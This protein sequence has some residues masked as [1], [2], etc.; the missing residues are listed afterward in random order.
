[1]GCQEAPFQRAIR[2]AVWFPARVNFP[3]ITRSPW[4]SMASSTS[5]LVPVPSPRALQSW[6]IEAHEKSISANSTIVLF[7]LIPCNDYLFRLIPDKNRKKR[8]AVNISPKA[9]SVALYPGALS[10]HIVID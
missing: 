1:M 6:A 3:A 5:L 8:Y 7:I 2:L 10:F 4:N 9:D